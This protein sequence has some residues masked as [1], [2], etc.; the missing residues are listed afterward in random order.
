MRCALITAYQKILDAKGK[1]YQLHVIMEELSELIKA[2]TKYE[3]GI[4][5][6]TLDIIEETADVRNALEYVKLIYDI[7]E[8]N[9]ERCMR[10][11][12]DSVLDTLI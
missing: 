2:I 7:Q 4:T 3:R 6:D 8:D 11:K 12:V 9:I 10:D 5:A 1:E